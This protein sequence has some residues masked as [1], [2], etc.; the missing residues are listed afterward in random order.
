MADQ[1]FVIKDKRRLDDEG[2]VKQDPEP[3]TEPRAEASG[4]EPETGPGG[5]PLPE[6]N[7]T[8]I[9]ISLSSSALFNLGQI[10]DPSTGQ[11][12]FDLAVAKQTIDMLV[13]L[14]D[15]T[16]GNL[17]EEEKQLMERILYDLRMLY[18]QA[19]KSPPQT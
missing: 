17:D 9:I 6:V 10:P 5:A 8:T 4:P 16:K 13:V 1:D 19:V 14:A 7:F 15:K 12:G 3:E 11:T 18:V 2:E